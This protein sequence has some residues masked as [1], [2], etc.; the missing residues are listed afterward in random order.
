MSPTHL[1]R[2]AALAVALPAF[3][4]T[5]EQSPPPT[6]AVKEARHNVLSVNVIANIG[7]AYSIEYS[8]SLS[9]SFAVF[10]EP[11]YFNIPANAGFGS[12]GIVGP[13]AVLG[14][15]W[16]PF[17]KGH[18]GLLIAPS[19]YG[20]YISPHSTNE[21]AATGFGA[22]LVAGWNFILFEHMVLSPGIGGTVNLLGYNLSGRPG[23]GFLPIIRTNIG[24]AF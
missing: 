22:G 2:L 13:G 17:A 11:T 6:V 18:D 21:P 24:V 19:V 9:P 4:Q 15:Q 10:I 5:P 7:G 23:F 8:R 16:F 12:L 1:L 3:A 14:V 20:T